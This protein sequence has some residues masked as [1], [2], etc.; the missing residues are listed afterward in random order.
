MFHKV[1]WVWICVLA[2][3]LVTGCTVQPVQPTA[4][5]PTAVDSQMQA[6]VDALRTQV[7]AQLQMTP[8][9]VT[10][11]AAEAVDWPDACLGA[12]S[13]QE[14]CAQVV[15][16]GYRITLAVNG[17]EYVYHTDRGPY[18][19]R[20]V[21][22][23]PVDV[24]A[25]IITGEITVD[26]GGCQDVVVGSDGV[27]FGYCG[28]ARFGG[29]FVSP[30]RQAT[31]AEFAARYA[32]FEAQT[33]VGLIRF[34][35]SG[36]QVATP[37]EQTRLAQWV[38]LLV[39]EAAAGTP[40][41][42][43]AYHGPAEPGSE[44]ASQC[45]TLTMNAG[46]ATVFDCAGNVTTV[47]LNGGVLSRWLEIQDRFA[48]F[49]VETP[50]ERLE[51]TGMGAEASA[52]WQQALLAWARTQYAELSTGKASAAGNTVLAWQL[53]PVV[54]DAT[55]CKVLIVLAWG[56]AYAET[57]TC[58]GGE[59]QTS[60]QG[61]L[62]NAELEQLYTWQRDLATLEAEQGYLL[63]NGAQAPGAVERAEVAQWAAQVWQRLMTPRVSAAVNT[64]LAWGLGPSDDAETAC[65]HLTVTQAG[66]A[67]AEL[68]PCAGGA[69]QAIVVGQLT[70]AEQE[71]LAAWQRTYATLY[72]EPGYVVGNG[73]QVADAEAYAA[74]ELW[75]VD[76]WRRIWA[77]GAPQPGAISM[78]APAACP[79]PT[80]DAQLYVD[81]SG[82][83]CL[84]YPAAYVAETT[85]DGVV[86]LVRGSL[87]NHID[88]RVS[89]EVSDAAGRSL[90]EIGDAVVAEYAAGF[91]ILRAMATVGGEPALVL[92]NLPGQDLNRRV[93]V[94][95]NG[96]LYSFFFTPLGE[97]GEA[98]AA[99]EAF[100]QGVIDSLRLIE[101]DE[102]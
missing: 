61:W 68:R 23:P 8:A 75:I 3:G 58:D 87:M 13:P 55:V 99:F 67:Y 80:G 94:I 38:Q 1:H 88:P 37:A 63:G 19:L 89:I 71:Y 35:G 53:D 91:D 81:R 95:H 27:A 72:A 86:H 17:A 44:D 39:M 56:E 45:A 41:G 100:Y 83:F 48:P 98:R 65:M 52:V 29:K 101:T 26:H 40:M 43:L 21:Q 15:T 24:G 102:K 12:G 34:A 46:E 69:V 92:D 22:G 30:A 57:R 74:I 51:F 6:T 11:V 32:P 66:D 90:T 10:V 96:R 28:L 36:A 70:S 2:I 82:G 4:Q 73:A 33:E 50:T 7:A 16:P 79:T 31:L 76:L 59:V 93:L 60:T 47:K 77:S 42:G 84:L 97:E 62:E 85:D 64:V 25:P 14:G 49:V 54:D 5:P 9:D 78:G 20:L 18:W